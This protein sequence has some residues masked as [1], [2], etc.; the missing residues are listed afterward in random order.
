MTY[1]MTPFLDQTKAAQT[2]AGSANISAQVTFS[3][4]STPRWAKPAM[5]KT[6]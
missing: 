6:R 1:V 3:H 2:T 5:C 4:D